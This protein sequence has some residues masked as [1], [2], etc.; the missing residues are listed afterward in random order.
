MICPHCGAEN[1]DTA[2]LCEKCYYRFVFGHAHGD[3]SRRMFFDFSSDDFR[4]RSK[5]ARIIF[6]SVLVILAY[7]LVRIIFDFR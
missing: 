7:L 2:R 3:P 5:S 4:G 6:W 1:P